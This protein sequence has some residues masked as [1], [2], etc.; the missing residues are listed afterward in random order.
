MEANRILLIPANDTS[1]EI[2]C[3]EVGAEDCVSIPVDRQI[4]LARVHKVLKRKG[5]LN[6][7]MCGED[8]LIDLARRTAIKNGKR[9]MLNPKEF[10]VLSMLIRNKNQ[11]LS[12][13]KILDEVWGTD[14][15]GS[16]HTV[17]VKISSLRKKLGL[18][19]IIK[20]VP[21]C[22]YILEDN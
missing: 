2:K 9:I 20:T 18:H 8:V 21:K 6:T 17:D 14:Y 5:S 7:I 3:L 15:F 16:S 10:E 4:L 11:V 12:R 1:S 13:Q 22:G 19:E